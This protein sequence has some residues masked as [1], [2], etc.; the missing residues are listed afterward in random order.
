M[1]HIVTSLMFLLLYGIFPFRAANAEEQEEVIIVSE[2]VGEVIDAEERERFG[3]WPD[4]EGFK[5]AT[6]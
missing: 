4:I 6:F 2:E 1:K 5:S 3:L